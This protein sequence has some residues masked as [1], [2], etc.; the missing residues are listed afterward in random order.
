MSLLLTAAAV[1]W[2]P[3]KPLPWSGAARFGGLF[4]PILEF[5]YVPPKQSPPPRPLLISLPGLD[6]HPLT[7]F[8]QFPR[9]AE[10]YDVQAWWPNRSDAE[11]GRDHDGLVSEVA[12]HIRSC[13]SSERDVYLMGESFGGV[14]A[15]AVANA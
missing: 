12:M 11:A 6:G 2:Q 9:L 15:L 13:A 8:V 5:P 14:Q 10:E 7:A 1:A 3:S 4:D